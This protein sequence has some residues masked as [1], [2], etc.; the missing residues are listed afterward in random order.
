MTHETPWWN[1]R[2]ENLRKES[3]KLSNRYR[4]GNLPS[5]EAFKEALRNYKREI[6]RSKR[7][8]WRAFCEEV[9]NLPAATRL[10]KAMSKDRRVVNGPLLDDQ[11][12]FT[13]SDREALH[14]LM[15]KHFPDCQFLSGLKDNHQSEDEAAPHGISIADS[16]IVEVDEIVTEE[17]VRH[18]MNMFSP[19]KSP[20]RDGI[21]PALLQRGALVLVPHLVKLYQACL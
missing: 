7:S 10:Q 19:F 11:N 9:S 5:E 18:A 14:V 21:I 4:R 17:K 16:S 3:R 13:K 1:E 12:K 15:A 8:S 2:I 6:R 20:G